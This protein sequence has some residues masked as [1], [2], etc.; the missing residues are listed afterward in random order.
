MFVLE[1]QNRVGTEVANCG[2]QLSRGV[3]DPTGQL[4]WAQHE[5]RAF[6]FDLEDNILQY[7]A[8]RI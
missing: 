1:G 7:K 8:K 4:D 2:A 5:R 3:L 6:T